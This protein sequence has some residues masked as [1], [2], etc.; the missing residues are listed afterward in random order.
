[1]KKR[2][3]GKNLKVSAVSLGCMGFTLAYGF[4]MDEKEAAKA[5]AQAVDM[6][7]IYI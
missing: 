7:Y 3:L 1:M 6:G 4:A 5:I 2:I